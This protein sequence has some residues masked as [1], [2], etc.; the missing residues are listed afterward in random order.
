MEMKNLIQLQERLAKKVITKDR[1]PEKIKLVCGIDQA[2][3]D[4]KIISAAVVCD[5]KTL[6]PIEKKCA[7][8]EETFPYIPTFLS[9]REGPAILKVFKKIKSKPDVLIINGCGINHPRYFGLASHIGV[10]LDVSTIGITQNKLCGKYEKE[11]KIGGWEPLSYG[12]KI[13][14]G[15]F[16]SKKGCRGIFVGPG[17]KIA[18]E[19]A[20]KIT[21]DCMKDHKLPEPLCYAHK[22]A[23]GIKKT[24]LILTLRKLI[25]KEDKVY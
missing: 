1:L 14:G 4:E 7:I 15:V 3:F 21:Q 13:V 5:Y 19:T 6:N 24:Y 16:K 17:H 11:P 2:F 18:Y 9:F 22:Y 25:K 20:I 23:N 8:T 10:L 12:G